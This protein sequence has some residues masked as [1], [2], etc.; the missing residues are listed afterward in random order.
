MGNFTP[1]IGRNITS[2]VSGSP[3]IHPDRYIM[4]WLLAN[5]CLPEALWRRLSFPCK[6]INKVGGLKEALGPGLW[7]RVSPPPKREQGAVGAPIARGYDC[8]VPFCDF[9]SLSSARS[10]HLGSPAS[11][12]GSFYCLVGPTLA[13]SS[14]ITTAVAL[15]RS[16]CRTL[17]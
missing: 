15:L 8:G 13:P 11:S 7:A 10:R 9:P 16:I 12:P 17:L 6:P 4:N 1:W 3:W 2:T 5:T 14:L